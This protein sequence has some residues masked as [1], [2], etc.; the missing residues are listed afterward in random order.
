MKLCFVGNSHLGAIYR[1]WKLV[2]KEYPSINIDLFIER[3]TGVNPLKIISG[4]EEGE[5]ITRLEQILVIKDD[6]IDVDVYDYFFVFALG[7]SIVPVMHLYKHCRADGHAQSEGTRLVSNECFH[8]AAMGALM[9]SKA[10]S[11]ARAVREHSAKPIYVVAQARPS[12]YVLD[13]SEGTVS[14]Y[15][16]AVAMRDDSS[17]NSTYVEAAQAVCG[18]L[19]ATLIDQPEETLNGSL[20]THGRFGVADP[21]DCGEG[22]SYS[23]GDWWHMNDRYGLASL[24]HALKHLP[25]MEGLK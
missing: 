8:A 25:S 11:L 2:R 9:G 14:S 19:G 15:A 18:P 10:I 23:I 4:S 13:P 12:E 24:S 22:S 16:S 3:S 7:L 17:L 6:P 5:H 1:A 20:F 21:R